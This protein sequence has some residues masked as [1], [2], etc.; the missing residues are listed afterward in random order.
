M[1]FVVIKIDT[2]EPNEKRTGNNIVAKVVKVDLVANAVPSSKNR[3]AEVL[4]ADGTGSI[5]FT[6]ANEQIDVCKVGETIVLRNAKVVVFQKHMRLRVD[7]WGLVETATK[8]NTFGVAVNEVNEKNN[9]SNKEF[10][11]QMIVDE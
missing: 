9:L 11:V 8:E 5:V 2:L 6:A 7:K 1:C 10:K 4:I 3:I